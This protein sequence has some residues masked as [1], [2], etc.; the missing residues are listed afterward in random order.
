MPHSLVL[1]SE[2]F[3]LWDF[4]VNEVAT[5]TRAI[6]ISARYLKNSF[7]PVNRLPPEVLGLIPS[8]LPS[9]RDLVNATAVCRHWR[10]VLLSSP[11]L[12]CDI[13]C[14]GNRGSIREYM[15]RECLGRS[16]TVPLNVRL[17]SVRYLPDITPH[18]PRL[19]TLEIEVVVQ[20]QLGKIASHFSEPAPNLWRLGISGVAPTQVGISIPLGL[21]G[22][23]FASLR[24]LQLVGFSFLIVP[25]HFPH[26][27]QFDV[28]SHVHAALRIDGVL[29]ALERMPSLEV[30]HLEFCPNHHPP[31]S[32]APTRRSVTLPKLREVKLSSF[33]DPDAGRPAFTPPLLSALALPSAEQITIGVLPPTSSV[34][35]PNSFEEQLPNFAETATVDFFVGP[36]ILNILFYG[37][38]GSRLLFTTSCRIHYPFLRNGFRGTPFLSVRKMTLNITSYIGLEEYILGLL[39]ALERLECLEIR[40][41]HI[42]LL[43]LWSREIDQRSICPSLQSLVVVKVPNDPVSG[44]LR[45]FVITR[46]SHGVPLVEVVEVVSDG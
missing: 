36:E 37:L 39:R 5:R 12:W 8:S 40:G 46:K 16:R 31:S 45:E 25:Q 38:R 14:S 10:D 35:L 43:S 44:P 23:D 1:T 22:G 15:F 17:T 18:L 7:L 2:R 9:K 30:L 24:T 33:G 11:D 42:R 28:K 6:W 20:E 3:D 13:D 29:D 34:V 27:T 41:K 32:S 26:L 19:S 4:Q 21:F